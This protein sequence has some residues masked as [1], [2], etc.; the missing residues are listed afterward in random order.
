MMRFALI[1]H[2]GRPL[3]RPGWGAVQNIVWN[4]KLG[5]E[6][7]GHNVDVFHSPA[8]H[9]TIHRIN[10]SD[11]DFVHCH[12]EHFVLQC[13]AHLQA[14]YVVTSH[15]GGFARFRPGRSDRYPAFNYLYEDCLRAPGLFA[16]SEPIGRM[17][18]DSGYKGFLGVLP[19]AVETTRFRKAP[20]GNGRA[21]CVGEIG[22]RKRQ[23]VLACLVE[24]RVPVDFVGPWNRQADPG[25][26]PT[27]WAPY[28]GEWDR[29]TL[30]ERLT[31]YSCLVLLSES[32]AAPLVVLEALAAG[33]S[34]VVTKACAANLDPSGFVTVLDD[35]EARAD[36]VVAGLQDAI[37][38]NERL[39]P[40][41][42]MYAR[43]VFDYA[44]MIPRYVAL[45]REFADWHGRRRRR[46][47][48]P[49]GGRG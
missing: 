49:R 4:Y 43:D 28:L 32:E 38:N 10:H 46:F 36:V 39:R 35:D 42:V 5:L 29:R 47:S 6:A 19:N 33:L 22:S 44:V 14:P 15:Y 34:V 31:D 25:Y 45:A 40:D 3:P 7:L 13:N 37:E 1:T 30:Y 21:I 24:G 18:R 26:E 23:A 2:G 8:I 20:R 16:L 9:E 27:E 48:W 17:F 12:N 41:I 11:Y